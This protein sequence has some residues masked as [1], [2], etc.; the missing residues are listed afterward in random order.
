MKTN[1]SSSVANALKVVLTRIGEPSLCQYGAARTPLDSPQNAFVF[2]RD[3]V[4]ADPAFEPEKEHLVA[5]LLD[6]KL[7][8]KAYHVV[9]V[10]TVNETAAHPR[11]V[12]RAAIVGAAYGVV[13]MHNHPSGDP[14]PSQADRRITATMREAAT[15]LQIQLIDHVVCGDFKAGG[16]P[17]FSFRDAGLL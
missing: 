17:F 8:P 3:V 6:T 11:E 14:S 16:M 7:K 13:L 15:L 12:F 2:W 9:S 10:G 4:A 1:N 5:V